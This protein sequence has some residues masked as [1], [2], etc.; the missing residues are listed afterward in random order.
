LA[1]LAACRLLANVE[2]TEAELEDGAWVDTEELEDD[3]ADLEVTADFV[4]EINNDQLR[5]NQTRFPRGK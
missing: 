5:T 1:E 2:L 3:V 4:K